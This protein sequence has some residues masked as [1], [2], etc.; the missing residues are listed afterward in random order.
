M[1]MCWLPPSIGA[2]GSVHQSCDSRS[3][4]GSGYPVQFTGSGTAVGVG[5]GVAVVV[6]SGVGGGPGDGVGVGT[7]VGVGV[8]PFGSMTL[9]GSRTDEFVTLPSPTVS[10]TT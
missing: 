4:R 8:G 2:V 1:W 6:G 7:A 9:T 5:V 10:A 3:A